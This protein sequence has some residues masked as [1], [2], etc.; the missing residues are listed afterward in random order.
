M[1]TTITHKGVQI[2]IIKRGSVYQCRFWHDG[3]LYRKSTGCKREREA[4]VKARRI[5]E[6]TAEMSIP[7][8]ITDTS[9]RSVA[10][11]YRISQ[12]QNASYTTAL[13]N[14]RHL[15]RH[16][17]NRDVFDIS[18]Q[19]VE[20]YKIQRT[21]IEQASKDTVQREL[22]V[23]TMMFKLA[24]R[25]DLKVPKYSEY[26]LTVR[27]NYYS[28]EEFDKIY[29]KIIP[30]LKPVIEFAWL[31][32]W[33]KTNITDLKWENVMF[34]EGII[35]IQ[36]KNTKGKKQLIAPLQG[37]IGAIIREQRE[38]RPEQAASPYVFLNTHGNKIG[39]FH[40]LW[41]E[42][43]EKAGLAGQDRKF[44][45]FRRSAA[46]RADEAGISD[47]VIADM[48]GWRGTKMLNRYRQ[49]RRQHV[50]EAYDKLYGG[51]NE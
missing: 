49:V 51:K 32:G 46:T 31:T 24:G 3:Q 20:W 39:N 19:E 35:L 38:S 33:R 10:E 22:S 9:F 8:S 37:R 23:L 15:K 25:I 7:A 48:V 40:V 4:I 45:D 6:L 11:V 50:I 13:V 18:A 44:H 14:L 43:L 41:A 36:R 27:E 2:R 26:E 42:A 5:Y 16:F 34:E 47:L 29:E 17:R 28:K 30:Y 21:N 1:D 12:M